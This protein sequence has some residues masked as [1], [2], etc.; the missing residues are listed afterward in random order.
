MKQGKVM[1]IPTSSKHPPKA[2]QKTKGP[3]KSVS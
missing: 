2:K 1:K 3:A